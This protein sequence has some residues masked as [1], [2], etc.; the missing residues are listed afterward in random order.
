MFDYITMVSYPLEGV[1]ILTPQQP[2]PTT[3]GAPKDLARSLPVPAG[4]TPMAGSWEMMVGLTGWPGNPSTFNPWQIHGAG[5]NMLTKRGYID[6][7]LW[8]C[9]T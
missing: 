3:P 4:T 7:T 9:Q 6:G 5:R 2:I 8:L 1:T